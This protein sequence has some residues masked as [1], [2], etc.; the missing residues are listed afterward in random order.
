MRAQLVIEHRSGDFLPT[1][2]AAFGP[3][4]PQALQTSAFARKS[5]R[6]A[7]AF[8]YAGVS[9]DFVVMAWPTEGRLDLYVESSSGRLRTSALQVWEIVRKG[10]HKLRPQLK[11]LVLFDEDTNDA[12]ARADVG[13]GWYGIPI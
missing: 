6:S 9:P 7:Q 13:A 5:P 8:R 11:S 1:L 12:V 10:K 3:H 4:D 2:R